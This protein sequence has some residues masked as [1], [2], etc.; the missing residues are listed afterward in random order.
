MRLTASSM[1]LTRNTAIG[2]AMALASLLVLAWSL[3]GKPDPFASGHAVWADFRNV[4][5]LIRFDRYVRIGGANVGT[6]GQVERRGDIAHVELDLQGSVIGAVRADATAS[7]RPHTLF[8]GNSFIELDPGSPS[9]PPLGNHTIPLS[10]TTNYVTVDKATRVFSAPTRV[11][12]RRV[13]AD[14]DTTLDAATVSALR[15]TFAGLPALTANAS[16]AARAAQGPTGVELAGSIRG[17]ARTVAGIAGAAPDIGPALQSAASTAGAID[18]VGSQLDRSLAALPP[19]LAATRDGGAALSATIGALEPLARDLQPALRTLAPTLRAL[20]PSLTLLAP[21]LSAAGPFADLLHRTLAAG[22]DAAG[23]T[24]SLLNALLP[25]VRTT[26]RT[27]IPFLLSKTPTGVSMI[28]ALGG[29]G[30]GA[31]GA[32]SPVKTLAQGAV[33]NEGS[34]HI[35]YTATL[36]SFEVAC[37]QVPVAALATLLGDLQLCEP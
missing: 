3:L 20:R 4:S 2:V 30:A 31:A 21:A 15:R 33:G 13:L 35:F 7:L 16:V 5:S 27:L 37:S 9:A 6:I 22:A 36:A 26:D 25:T 8:D 18:A 29:T 34:G 10:R 23:P 14:V 17:F 28:R 1:R 12:L 11:S 19:A 24:A 32:L